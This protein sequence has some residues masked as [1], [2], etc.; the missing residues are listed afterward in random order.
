MMDKVTFGKSNTLLD[1]F[2]RDAE[3][4]FPCHVLE[5]KPSV[6]ELSAVL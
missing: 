5:G 1:F 3:Q 4:H 2:L 6:L